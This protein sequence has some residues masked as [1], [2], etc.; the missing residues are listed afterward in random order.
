MASMKPEVLV[1][2]ATGFLGA[3]VVR[4]LERREFPVRATHRRNSPRWHLGDCDP[5]WRRVDLDEPA[6]LD[7]AIEGCRA[8]VDCS[9]FYP[10][11]GVDADG[12]RRRGV[13]RLRHVLDACDRSSV[14][15]VV[16]VSSPATLGLTPGGDR[17]RLSE[18]DRYTPGEV[19]DAYFEAKYSMEAEVY[20]YVQ[21]GTP[22]VVAIPGAVFGPGDVK[23]T[24]GEYV[25]RIASGSV[26]AVV[27]DTL[28]VVDVR[29]VAETLVAAVRDGRPGRR[30]LIGGH[31]LAARGFTERVA[32][33]AGVEPP[34]RHVSGAW[35][36][37]MVRSGERWAR[38]LG[39]DG[40]SPLVPFDL[41][42]FARPL[43]SERAE[44]ELGHDVRPVGA[45]IRDAVDWF[46]RY[47]YI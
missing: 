37:G 36:R 15:R 43:S 11:D 5:E 29:D 22:V 45:T 42:H 40:P 31:N 1:L 39:Y 19:D 10:T 23:P 3:H 17:S 6:G 46:R 8:V 2:G 47:D 38:A 4:E 25:V 24:S 34:D 30:Y 9:G 12:A 44:G 28:N 33:E 26:P 35:I 7:A 16:Y 41:A 18:S 32:D 20:R 14:G 21:G 13:R 27:G